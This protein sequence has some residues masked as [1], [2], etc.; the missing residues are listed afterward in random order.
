MNKNLQNYTA[1]LDRINQSLEK[2][3]IAI[4]DIEAAIDSVAGYIAFLEKKVEC[5]SDKSKTAKKPKPK[6]AKKSSARRK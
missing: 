2:N 4:E 5:L 1:A 3:T 6:A